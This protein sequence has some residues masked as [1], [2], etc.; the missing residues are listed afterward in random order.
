[1]R[2]YLIKRVQLSNLVEERNHLGKR[3]LRRKDIFGHKTLIINGEGR[4]GQ[5]EKLTTY[6]CI[7]IYTVIS[8]YSLNTPTA[9]PTTTYLRQILKCLTASFPEYSSDFFLYYLYTKEG[10]HKHFTIDKLTEVIKSTAQS[11]KSRRKVV[12]IGGENT[13]RVNTVDITPTQF[14]YKT[15]DIGNIENTGNI[16]NIYTKN[17]Y[18]NRKNKENVTPNNP[19]RDIIYNNYN[20]GESTS[21]LYK[22]GISNKMGLTIDKYLSYVTPYA[23]NRGD[24]RLNPLSNSTRNTGKNIYDLNNQNKIVEESESQVQ[25]IFVVN[26]LKS[27][28]IRRMEDPKYNMLDYSSQGVSTTTNNWVEDLLRSEVKEDKEED[29]EDKK[30]FSSLSLEDEDYEY[31]QLNTSTLEELD[32]FGLPLGTPLSPFAES[33]SNAHGHG[34]RHGHGDLFHFPH[35]GVGEEGQI[36]YSLNDSLR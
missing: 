24:K 31:T 8:A 16:E 22:S 32:P 3:E 19:G 23:T 34:H 12:H 13:L 30:E 28:L 29:V 18:T 25:N 20:S 4:W 1:M 33:R 10:V 36:K 14:N 35:I 2:L 21:E 5:I 9:P 6:E 11:T 17:I 26:R 15:G 27:N 7:P